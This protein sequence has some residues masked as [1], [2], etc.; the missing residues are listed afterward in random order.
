MVPLSYIVERP[1]TN[2][3]LSGNG[4]YFFVSRR[5]VRTST[6]HCPLSPKWPLWR[7]FVCTYNTLLPSTL[8]KNPAEIVISKNKSTKNISSPQNPQNVNIKPRKRPPCVLVT[9][10]P[11][12]D[13]LEGPSINS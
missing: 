11:M 8:K 1:L 5:T 13:I 9:N 4:D 3:H 7:R 10:V 6:F 2:G 12:R